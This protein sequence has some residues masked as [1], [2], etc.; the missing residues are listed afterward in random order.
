[1][2]F[3]LL[4]HL[5]AWG[6]RAWGVNSK[7]TI[8]SVPSRFGEKSKSQNKWAASWQNQQNDLSAQ[9]RLI[10]LGNCW[11][12]SDFAVRMKKHWVFY[13]L[14]NQWGVWTDQTGGYPGWSECSLGACHFVGFVLW[15]LKLPV[16]E[17]SCVRFLV[18][19]CAFSTRDI[20][21]PMW[22]VRAAKGL[23]RQF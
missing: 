16:C 8:L 14:S 12:W 18:G 1:M 5:V 23:S 17:M 11:V 19:L 9:L 4:W 20:W 22:G 6:V 2:C 7:G 13:P 21:W 10:S 15:R 3:F